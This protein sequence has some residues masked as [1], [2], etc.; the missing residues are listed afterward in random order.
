[1]NQLPHRSLS[2]AFMGIG[3]VRDVAVE[4]FRHRYLG[5]EGAPALR[6]LNV[7]LFENDFATVISDLRCATF[8]FDLIEWRNR[9]IAEHALKTQAAV[10][11]FPASAF[12]ARSRFRRSIE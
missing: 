9:G 7:L 4:I 5:R 11:L 3:A 10:F 12:S 1:M 2:A 6:D 8:P